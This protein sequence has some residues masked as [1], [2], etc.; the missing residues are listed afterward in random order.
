M[1]VGYSKVIITPNKPMTMSGYDNRHKMAKDV[2]DDLYARCLIIKINGDSVVMISLDLL[3]VDE[4]LTNKIKDALINIDE[5]LTR[6]AIFVC[7]THTHSGP[8]NLFLNRDGYNIE[9]VDDI[10]SKC[11][12]A[13]V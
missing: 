12:L 1:I 10:V 5:K 9:Y 3:G 2:H 4:T 13:L 11:K 8:S 6:K 7:A